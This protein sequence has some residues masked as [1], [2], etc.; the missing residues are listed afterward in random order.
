MQVSLSKL[1]S[2]SLWKDQLV[3]IKYLSTRAKLLLIILA[4][5]S[6]GML[7]A[8]V[9]L[10]QRRRRYRP[11]TSSLGRQDTFQQSERQRYSHRRMDSF[12]SS[13]PDIII[14][15]EPQDG[16]KGRSSV[17][18]SSWEFDTL[19]SKSDVDI[20]L[21][22]SQ[23]NTPGPLSDDFYDAAGIDVL[24][25]SYPSM[26]DQDNYLYDSDDSF[27]SAPESFL[28]LEVSSSRHQL[29]ISALSL[30]DEG[31]IQCRT[32]RTKVLCCIDDKDFLAK[33]CCVRQ[34][35]S[36]LLLSEENRRFTTE[37]GRDMIVTLLNSSNHD[38]Q[39]FIDRYN[40]IIQFT[41]DP[42]NWEKVEHELIDRGVVYMNV[43]DIV[44]DFMLM[45]AFDDLSDPP[46]ALQSVIHNGWISSGIK[47]SML[48]TAVWSVLKTKKS[49]LR[50]KNGFMSRFYLMSETVSPV[51]AWG[52]LGTDTELNDR[53]MRFKNTMM[54][55]LRSV[56]SL[57][58][59]RY[60][61]VHTLST[62]IMAQAR[63]MF[64][65]LSDL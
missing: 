54:S 17:D 8:G 18:I 10:R 28:R 41:Q 40:D 45:D 34:A 62:D 21:S 16:V 39:A 11:I 55:F 65:S 56:F 7:T 37:A 64:N 33:L 42:Q 53:C 26:I 19:H 50:N 63:R 52:F 59:V 24:V 35:F 12:P 48:N 6:L 30:V 13:I 9:V 60:A 5:I 4:G 20:F 51:F 44:L 32:M 23:N 29:Y 38:S 61:T 47:Q 2:P 25:P 46:S 3:N 36:E 1:F 43:Y 22:L 14:E 49:L 15:E 27:A 57:D 31:K 58:T